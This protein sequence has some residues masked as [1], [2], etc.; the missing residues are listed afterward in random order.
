MGMSVSKI[1]AGK[2]EIANGFRELNDPEEQRRRLSIR[3]GTP[4][5]ADDEAMNG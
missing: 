3:S 5:A 4:N 2:M 1:F